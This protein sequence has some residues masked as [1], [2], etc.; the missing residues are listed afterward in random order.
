FIEK[1]KQ[2]Y[3]NAPEIL[4]QEALILWQTDRKA[5]AIRIA[6]QVVKARP[7]SF[8]NQQLIGEYYAGRDA[9]KTASAFEAYLAHRPSEFEKND[10]R[11][12]IHL[13][14]EYLRIGRS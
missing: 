14:F 7:Q 9:Q 10:V 11:P 13:G 4:E 6:E 1:A 12:R 5:D 2:R 3:P 8:L